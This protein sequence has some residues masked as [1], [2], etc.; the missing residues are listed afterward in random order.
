MIIEIFMEKIPILLLYLAGYY[1]IS[2]FAY[3]LFELI[4]DDD[5][6]YANIS[7]SNFFAIFIFGWL[8]IIIDIIAI[9]FLIYHYFHKLSNDLEKIKTKLKIK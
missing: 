7:P 6:I 9:P 8:F 2:Y 4:V 5:R 3:I 1:L